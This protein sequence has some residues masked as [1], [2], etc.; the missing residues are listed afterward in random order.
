MKTIWHATALLA[1]T[2]L[3]LGCG[4]SIAAKA[5]PVDVSGTVTNASGKPVGGVTL[6]FIPTTAMQTQG[7]FTLKADGKFSVK[8]VPGSY[9]YVFEGNVPAINAIPAKYQSND[10]THALE[11][12]SAGAPALEIKLGN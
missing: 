3:I 5:D 10:A 9:T 1:L 11:I 6:M 4:P 8:L 2:T 12:P 7:Y